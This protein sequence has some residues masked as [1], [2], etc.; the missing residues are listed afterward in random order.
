MPTLVEDLP[1]AAGNLAAIPARTSGGI[2][3]VD[4][5]EKSARN[6][7][8]LLSTILTTSV[9]LHLLIVGYLGFGIPPQTVRPRIARAAPP[10]PPIIE[11][12][13]LEAPPPPPKA[14]REALRDQQP[15]TAQDLPA[16]VSAISAV[17]STVNVAFGIRVVGPVHL[18]SDTAEASGTGLV[19][20]PAEPTE[21]SGRSLLI[22]M[23]NYPP[24]AL[25]RR[26]T[27]KVVVEFHTTSRGDIVDVRVRSSS[28][29]DVLDRAAL[30][31][32]RL[33]HWVGEAG[34]FTKTY[35]FILR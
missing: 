18:V 26:L 12:I 10:P 31:N 13:Q 7:G 32:L 24:D 23:L 21:V 34:Y 27:G 16:A 35:E 20:S 28:G 8:Q 1:A 29:Y 33:G 14:P 30:E 11:D 15:P 19:A 3:A 25:Y 9:C 22:P 2:P 4:R 17:P 5:P 6:G